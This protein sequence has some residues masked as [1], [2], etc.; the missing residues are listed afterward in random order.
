MAADGIYSGTSGK[1]RLNHCPGDFL[2]VSTDAFV[3]DTVITGHHQNRFAV[4]R[5]LKG[6]LNSA[7]LFRDFMQ[8]SQRAR[9][10]N[11]LRGSLSG[12]CNPFLIDGVNSIYDFCQIHHQNPPVIT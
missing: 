3:N 5:W 12:L 2:G 8:P 1:K 11:Q 7:N 4:Y 9:R 6:F 10:H